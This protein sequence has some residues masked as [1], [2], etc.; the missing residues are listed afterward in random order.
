MRSAVFV[1]L[2]SSGINY[3]S[4]LEQ[5]MTGRLVVTISPVVPIVHPDV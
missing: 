3:S 1:T 2:T 4:D 5:C